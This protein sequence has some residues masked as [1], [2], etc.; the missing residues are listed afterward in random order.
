[1]LTIYQFGTQTIYVLNDVG[2]TRHYASKIGGAKAPKWIKWVLFVFEDV[3]SWTYNDFHKKSLTAEFVI[4]WLTDLIKERYCLI[5]NFGEYCENK[6]EQKASTI[7]SKL[8]ALRT[9]FKWAV[10]F[11]DQGRSNCFLQSYDLLGVMTVLAT[12]NAGM[13]K[14]L[15]VE[16][17]K[18]TME[19]LIWAGLSPANGLQDCQKAVSSEQ[20]WIDDLILRGAIPHIDERTHSK[21]L[22]FIVALIH[23]KAPTGRS[24]GLADLRT[25][26]IKE[27]LSEH[28]VMTDQ[29][30][31]QLQYH[32]MPIIAGDAGVRSVIGFFLENVR[33]YIATTASEDFFF[34]NGKFHNCFICFY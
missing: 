20:P 17:N 2:F 12:M 23:I 25:H 5:S 4:D 14:Q 30:K 11:R 6:L 8:Q 34:I 27:L 22:C 28:V 3:L 18:Q 16:R 10:L 1:M 7:R 32:Y 21:L 15:N 19:Y 26:Q 9:V 33:P 24:Q 29:F 13:G 31:T